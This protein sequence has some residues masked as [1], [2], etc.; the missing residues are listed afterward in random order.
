VREGRVSYY[1]IMRVILKQDI[2][3]IGRKYEVKNVA[4]GYAN[5]FLIPRKL[6]DY[7]SPEAVK[8][9]EALQSAT[10][11]EAEIREKLTKKQIEMLK[12]ISIVLRKK[13]ND[14]G[15]LFEQIHPAEI[16][17]ALKEQV[18]I[19]I[20]P[21][22]IKLKEPIKEI[23]EHIVLAQIGEN[24]GEFKIVVEVAD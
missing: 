9:A 5:N 18:K 16:S 11:A 19:K 22:F 24:R 21:E 8:R 1:G 14:K 3:G 15:H 7:A 17:E 10:A 6:A 12:N 2:K 20:E 23:G 13:T 4:D